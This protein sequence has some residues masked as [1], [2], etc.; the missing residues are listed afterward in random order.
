MSLA[1]EEVLASLAGARVLP[2]GA[3]R[4][5][6]IAKA[7]ADTLGRGTTAENAI[8]IVSDLWDLLGEL[9]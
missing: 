1:A 6:L 2:A 3:D 4:D 9:L 5:S 8:R 7:V